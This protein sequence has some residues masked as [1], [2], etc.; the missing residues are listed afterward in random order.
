MKYSI[1][2][3]SLLIF[4]CSTADNQSDNENPQLEIKNPL[5]GS[6]LISEIHYIYADTTYIAE[7]SVIGRFIVTQESY[8]IMYNRYGTKRDSPADM[9]KM[10]DK[11]KL[12]SFQTTVFNSGMYEIND[13]TFITTADIAKVAGFEGGVQYYKLA[14]E[15]DGMSITMFDET[16]PSGKKPAWYGKLEIKFVLHKEE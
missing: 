16:Y 3:V 2:L 13:S 6:W 5:Q 7:M 11:E 12:Y 15:E 8:A 9:S 1:I 4:S 10:T 14:K